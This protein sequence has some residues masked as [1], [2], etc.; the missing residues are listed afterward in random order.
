MAFSFIH[1][2]YLLPFLFIAGLLG[3]YISGANQLLSFQNLAAHY[4]M[5]K[6]FV[7]QH[8][9]LASMI[10]CLVYIIS[11]TL[12]LPLALLLTLAGGA[13]LGWAAAVMIV[14]SATIGAT[15]LFIA[16]RTVFSNMFRQR[17]GGF[18]GKLEDGF[19]KDSFSYLLA[20]RLIPV[21][22]FWVVNIA[23]AF[24]GM[25]LGAFVLAT[26]I[27]IIPGTFIYVSIARGFDS[28]LASGV[29]PDL[30]I[31]SDI[32]I[33]GPLIALGVLALLPPIWRH[34]NKNRRGHHGQ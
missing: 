33:A 26:G 6:T 16:A 20:L 18:L 10:F 19:K 21:A 24:V 12:S 13:L 11:V 17:L 1:V 14:V 4:D 7:G 27:G 28:V 29:V 22:P 15:I 30:S 34:R 8:Y 32:K 5:L 25:K 3:F 2:K 9:G 31:L 23:P